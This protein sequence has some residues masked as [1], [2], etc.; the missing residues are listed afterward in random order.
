MIDIHISHYFFNFTHSMAQRRMIRD[1]QCF[2]RETFLKTKCCQYH[3]HVKNVLH[4]GVVSDEVNTQIY[5]Q[6]I[7]C[8]CCRLRFYKVRS[9]FAKPTAAEVNVNKCVWIVNEYTQTRTCWSACI[10]S[11]AKTRRSSMRLW[12]KI[13]STDCSVVDMVQPMQV[14][15]QLLRKIAHT[16]LLAEVKVQ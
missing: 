9:I 5:M 10:L 8:D 3:W 11:K 13:K 1:D 7:W 2:Q 12:I 6:M 15:A 16:L 4:L 14:W